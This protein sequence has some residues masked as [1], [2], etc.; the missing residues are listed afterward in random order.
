MLPNTP[1]KIIQEDNEDNGGLL[2]F[3]HY[4]EY[5]NAKLLLERYGEADNA[6]NNLRIIDALC[7][8]IRRGSF[9]ITK[10]LLDWCDKHNKVDNVI[11]NPRMADALCQATNYGGFELLL[12]WYGD[13]NTVDGVVNSLKIANTLKYAIEHEILSS[14]VYLFK[15]YNTNQEIA[16]V[17]TLKDLAN[18]IKTIIKDKIEK[19]IMSDYAHHDILSLIK[20]GLDTEDKSLLEYLTQAD[21]L[22]TLSSRKAELDTVPEVIQFYHFGLQKTKLRMLEAIKLLNQT[23]I[24]QHAAILKTKQSLLKHDTTALAD[25]KEDNKQV[26]WVESQQN[27]ETEKLTM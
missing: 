3:T 17:T 4:D 24:K 10:L 9:K 2:F 23:S 19:G 7:L 22:K 16:Q 25:I 18:K 6:L 11:N 27:T 13:H 12:N 15:K 20:T 14:A 8:A 26:S 5:E 1:K 21:F